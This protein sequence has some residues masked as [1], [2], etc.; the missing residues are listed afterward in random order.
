MGGGECDGGEEGD[1]AAEAQPEEEVGGG[2]GGRAQEGHGELEGEAGGL[3]DPEYEGGPVCGAE[4]LA[5]DG[6]GEGADVA[7][8]EDAHGLES[9]D[10]LVV[11]EALGHGVEAEESEEECEGGERGE[12]DPVFYFQCGGIV[13]YFST[14]GFSSTGGGGA[15]AAP[16]ALGE[17]GGGIIAFFPARE[18]RV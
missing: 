11:V 4:G 7:V 1:A 5:S 2:D 10:G 3:G 8:G 12:D 17:H 18:G 16:G 13:S 6:C 9:G 14:R 15:S